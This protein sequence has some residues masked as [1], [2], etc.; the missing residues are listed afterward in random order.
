MRVYGLTH[1]EHYKWDIWEAE[2]RE[3]HP[4]VETTPAEVLEE[5][6]TP[7][8]IAVEETQAETPVTLDSKDAA[9]GDSQDNPTTN[10]ATPED[11]QTG[12]K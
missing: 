5:L 12:N 1:L 9:G 6:P 8:Q 7:A 4:V 11:S 10:S 2:Y 3:K